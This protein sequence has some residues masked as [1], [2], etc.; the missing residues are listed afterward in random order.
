MDKEILDAITKS[1]SNMQMTALKEELA[2]ASLLASVQNDL[3]KLRDAHSK[4]NIE[5][6]DLMSLDRK[7]VDLEKR[8]LKLEVELLKKDIACANLTLSHVRDLAMAAFRNPTIYKTFNKQIP[9][10]PGSFFNST[11]EQETETRD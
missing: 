2:K 11:C 8:E 4:Q 7:F 3:Q 6:N 9:A 5:M 1:L 10:Q